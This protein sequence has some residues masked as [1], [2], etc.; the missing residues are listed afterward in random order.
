MSLLHSPK[1]VTNGLV[2]CLD[3]ADRKSYPGTGTIWTD[4]SGNG[5]NGIHTG[6]TVSNGSMVFNG[7]SHIEINNPIVNSS[8]TELTV[9]VFFRTTTARTELI[10]ENGSNYLYN[11]FY[12]AKENTTQLTFEIYGPT[13]DA[14][15]CSILYQINQWYHFVGSWK[16]GERADIYLNGIKSNGVSIGSIIS[17]LI[18][19]NTNFFIGKRPGIDT[20]NFNGEIPIVKVYNRKLSDKEIE[21][22]FN[23]ARGRFGI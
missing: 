8:Y 10:L 23:V 12:L 5:N 22:N 20:Y 1:I 15:F 13:Y 14:R 11:S 17:N 3:A 19:G 18:N 21:Q 7:S 6:V 16:A 4:R 2:L 9:E